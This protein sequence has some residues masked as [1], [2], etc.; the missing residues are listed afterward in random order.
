M[1]CFIEFMRQSTYRYFDMRGNNQIL[2]NLDNISDILY[3]LTQL[4]LEHCSL[5]GNLNNNLTNGFENMVEIDL[6]WNFLTGEIPFYAL[7]LTKNTLISLNLAHNSFTGILS[8]IIGE[9]IELKYLNVSNNQL[10]GRLPNQLSKLSNLKVLDTHF[11]RFE[12]YLPLL[13]HLP[14]LIE[15][16]IDYTFPLTPDIQIIKNIG[17]M[18]Y[19]E[20]K[21]DRWKNDIKSF[22]TFIHCYHF[23]FK[24]SHH[25]ERCLITQQNKN[26]V[27]VFSIIELNRFIVS[28]L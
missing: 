10:F 12:S 3:K 23:I 17:W 15:V 18:S 14:E 25:N 7:K 24:L 27:T 4:R 6:S 8:L 11:N 22:V 20:M 2:F 21:N 9:M 28:Y 26:L 19:K 16:N 5:V 1:V 13:A